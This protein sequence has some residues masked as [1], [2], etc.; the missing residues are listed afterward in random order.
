MLKI[1]NIILLSKKITSTV[2]LLFCCVLLMCFESFTKN[3]SYPLKTQCYNKHPYYVGILDIKHD[4][5]N[6]VLKI[7]VRLFTNDLEEALKKTTSKAI[8]LLN[9]KDKTESDSILSVYLKKHLSFTINNKSTSLNYLGY[10]KEEASIWSYLE[11]KNVSAPKKIGIKAQLL[12]DFLPQQTNII[13]A[14]INGIE[15]SSKL[16]NPENT[17]ELVY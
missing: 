12:Y 8:D 4:N 15:K 11:I 6:K 9:P 13:H 10:E 2:F 16:T 5:N 1:K 14:E 7:S 17:V 3:T